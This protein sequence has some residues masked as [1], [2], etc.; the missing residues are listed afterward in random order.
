MSENPKPPKR[1]IVVVKGTDPGRHY[2]PPTAEP[3][4]VVRP[5]VPDAI[6]NP[7]KPFA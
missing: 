2:G 7:G 1:P 4:E 3:I 5:P 6:H